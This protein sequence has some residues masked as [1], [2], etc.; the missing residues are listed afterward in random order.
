MYTRSETVFKGVSDNE[1][2]AKIIASIARC[3]AEPVLAQSEGVL[4]FCT[5]VY[6]A[7]DDRV[8]GW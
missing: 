3:T 6:W 2:N 1:E 4:S 7:N 5:S 8:E